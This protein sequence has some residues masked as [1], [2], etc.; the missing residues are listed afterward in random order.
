MPQSIDALLA[1]LREQASCCAELQQAAE[2]EF[3]A[4]GRR[5]LEEMHAA[6][7][8]KEA[9]LLKW[10]KLEQRRTALIGILAA[11]LQVPAAGLTM[12]SLAARLPEA[13]ARRVQ[14]C[15]DELREWLARLQQMNHRSEALC[16]G[17]IDMLQGA[18]RLLKGFWIGA[19]VYQGD[20]GYPA[21]RLSG[22]LV[23]G[24]V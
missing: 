24:E 3:Q 18:H 23:R 15:R 22:R 4:L 17:A 5:S 1:V 20:G 21:A 19:P 12:A 13:Q 10:S 8:A 2:R 9:I 6:A 7:V 11:E 16:Q 14:R